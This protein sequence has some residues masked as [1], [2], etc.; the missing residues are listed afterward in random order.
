MEWEIMG[1]MLVMM[2]GILTWGGVMI[3]RPLSKR[4]GDLLELRVKQA[5]GEIEDPQAQRMEQLL[6]SIASR[7]SLVEER[8]D[9]AESLLRARTGARELPTSQKGP[10]D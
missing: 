7:I 5:R 9:F 1:P 8:Q 6:E 2:T 4:L 10:W 3:F